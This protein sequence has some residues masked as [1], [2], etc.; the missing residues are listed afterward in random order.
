VEL[1]HNELS[2]LLPD[3]LPIGSN[4]YALD[5]RSNRFVLKIFVWIFCLRLDLL[6]VFRTP[7]LICKACA[8]SLR[9]NVV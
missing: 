3:V 6:A 8:V 2:G 4:L 5:I 7:G 1:D 9:R